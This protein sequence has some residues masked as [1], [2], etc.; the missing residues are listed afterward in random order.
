MNEK[1]V[2][3]ITH[4][5]CVQRRRC[6]YGQVAAA[7]GA[8]AQYVGQWVTRH[9]PPA[10]QWVVCSQDGSYHPSALA[11]WARGGAPAPEHWLEARGARGAEIR[12][13]V[14]AYE[15]FPVASDREWEAALRAAGIEVEEAPPDTERSPVVVIRRR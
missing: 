6:T 9:I 12:A 4:L 5:V 11:A 15:E 14:T 8:R 2:Q 10:Q 1:M 13:R 3:A 7:L